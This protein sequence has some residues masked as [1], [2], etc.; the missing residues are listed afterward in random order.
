MLGC[1]DKQTLKEREAIECCGTMG[2]GHR[3]NDASTLTHASTGK[4]SHRPQHRIHHHAR[5]PC[6]SPKKSG[7]L[8]SDLSPSMGSMQEDMGG[9]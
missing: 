8:R 4:L 7:R 3:F 6:A 9:V 5:A 1:F 2:A